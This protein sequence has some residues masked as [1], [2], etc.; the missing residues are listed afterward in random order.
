MCNRD[1][2]LMLAYQNGDERAFAELFELYA[3]M[4][5]RYFVRH[6]KRSADAED[7][8]QETFLRLVRS[9]ADFRPG[10]ALRPWLFTIARNVCH[11]H[12]RR[13]Q[14][15]PEAPYEV[16]TLEA[17]QACIGDH[18]LDHAKRTEALTSALQLL[19]AAERRLV[20]EHWFDERAFSEIA[21]REG[22][23]CGTL[24][25]RAHRACQRLRETLR[26]A[27]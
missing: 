25:V 17:P 9:R 26:A 11:D 15:R 13:A 18:A 24:R 12:G 7:L 5:E 3:P 23:Q 22:V 20:D 10:E 21:L 14:R 19:P 2:G 6:G 1:A 8:T 4:L 27:A 16:D